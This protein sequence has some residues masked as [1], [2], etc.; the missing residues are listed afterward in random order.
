VDSDRLWTR[1]FAGLLVAELAYF[2]CVGLTFQVLPPY[3]AGPVGSDKAG[4][5]LAVGAFGI[6]ALVCRPFAGRIVDRHGRRP[7]LAVGALLALV[8]M[9]LLATVDTVPAI[10]AVRLVAGVAEAAFSV[11]S[12][13][14]LVDIAPRSRMGSALSYNSLGLY[15]GLA[16]GPQLGEWAVDQ[17]GYAF[18]FRL[19]A[20]LMAASLVV[21]LTSVPE[22]MAVAST[23]P[24]PL[25]HRATLPIA[26]GFLANLVGAGG[27]LAFASLRA[28]EVELGRTGTALFLYGVTVIVVRLAFVAVVDRIPALRLGVVALVTTASGLA[29][30]SLGSSAVGLLLGAVLV[31]VGVAFSTPAF[32]AAAFASVGPTERGAVSGTMMA[33]I[34][35]SFGLAP[36]GLGWLADA[37]GIP[38]AW[39][40]AAVVGLAGAA[41]T[42]ALDARRRVEV[43]G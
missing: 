39:L 11:A 40:L 18:A 24:T 5:G 13:T 35:L 30:A 21:V 36:I 20:A 7:L 17:V 1:A 15:L 34:D 32:F 19:G 33:T 4:A 28:G 23:E 16:F 37:Q 9:V 2:L 41:W 26:V 14:V 8:S 42:L 43:V 31:A 25:V 3:V 27:F 38:S 12:I 22:T 10:V 29:L 6:T